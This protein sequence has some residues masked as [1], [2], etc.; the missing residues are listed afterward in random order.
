[1]V[2]PTLSYVFSCGDDDKIFMFDWDKSWERV[3]S[4]DDHEHYVMQMAINPKDTNMFASASLDR[5]IKVWT[6]GVSGKTNA[7]FSLVG[8]EAGVNC[9]D[10]CHE[11]EKMHLVS[12]SDDGVVKVWDYQTKACL[13]T[14]ETAHVDNVTS[15]IFHPDI[16]IILSAG[17]DDIINIWNAT[18]YRNE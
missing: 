17:E 15:V 6:I 16:P 4:Y 18:T 5:T 10:F 13:Y 2:H 8:H 12:G 14:F 9:L 7:N 3:N 1:M 11:T